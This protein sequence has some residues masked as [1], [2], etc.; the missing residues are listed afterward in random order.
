MDL[1]NPPM[2]NSL[3]LLWYTPKKPAICQPV[4]CCRRHGPL[5]IHQPCLLIYSITP[6]GF[7]SVIVLQKKLATG[8]THLYH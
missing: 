5:Q 3:P 2:H 7:T 8:S 1:A 6:L 4:S